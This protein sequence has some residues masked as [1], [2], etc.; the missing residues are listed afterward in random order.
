MKNYKNLYRK[1]QL[2]KE[3]YAP[4]PKNH[5]CP[6]CG[7]KF[8]FNTRYKKEICYRCG[9]YNFKNKKS[10]FMYRLNE[11]IKKWSDSYGKI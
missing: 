5:Q 10:E 3:Y 4:M 1:N 7:R 8:N 2:Y 11:Q 9:R 6:Y